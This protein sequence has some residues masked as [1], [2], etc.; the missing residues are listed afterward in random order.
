MEIAVK[1]TGETFSLTGD[2]RSDCFEGVDSF[3]YLGQ[4]I[5]LEDDD[6]PEVLHNIWRSRQVWG[7]LGKLLRREGADP[8][9]SENFYWVVVQVVLLFGANTWVM[10]EVMLKKIEG[11]HVGFLRQVT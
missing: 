4:V 2:D 6:R 5:H 8:I 9:I 3:K 1:C 7:R 10:S 11:A